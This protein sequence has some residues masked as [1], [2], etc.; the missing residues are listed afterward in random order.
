MSS[1]TTLDPRYEGELDMGRREGQGVLYD[2]HGRWRYE[3]Q[4]KDDCRH[5][6]GTEYGDDRRLFRGRWQKDELVETLEVGGG[7]AML[8]HQVLRLWTSW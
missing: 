2:E 5:G 4:W 7:M 1:L 6:E 3:G 8:T